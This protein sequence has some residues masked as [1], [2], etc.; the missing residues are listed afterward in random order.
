MLPSGCL[1][2][3][4]FILEQYLHEVIEIDGDSNRVDANNSGFLPI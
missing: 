3:H 4:D 1:L 2:K